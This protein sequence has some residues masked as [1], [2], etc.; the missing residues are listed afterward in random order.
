MEL[1]T[2]HSNT[3]RYPTSPPTVL[4]TTPHEMGQD[5]AQRTDL[6]THR[7][8][9]N[10]GVAAQDRE[11]GGPPMPMRTDTERSPPIGVGVCEGEAEEMGGHLD[12]QGILCGGGGF[13]E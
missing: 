9:T 4:E 10:E 12:G 5:G 1:G 3:S 7:Q 13:S 11:G 6:P 2:E 8:G